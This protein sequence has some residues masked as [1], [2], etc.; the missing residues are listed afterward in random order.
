M[1]HRLENVAEFVTVLEKID[2]FLEDNTIIK[3]KDNMISQEV[4]ST[5][6]WYKFKQNIPDVS[7]FNVQNLVSTI[8]DLTSK[9]DD[10]IIFPTVEIGEDFF[11]VRTTEE[12]SQLPVGDSG[13]IKHSGDYSSLYDIET[14]IELSE[15]VEKVI[16]FAKISETDEVILNINKEDDITSIETTN[17]MSEASYKREFK[18]STDSDPFIFNIDFFSKLKPIK[19]YTTYIDVDREDIDDLV[20]SLIVSIPISKVDEN[21][22]TQLFVFIENEEELI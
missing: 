16:K 13:M 1:S 19:S 10:K 8:S 14:E 22:N 15:V 6:F 3:I 7:V 20:C 5:T 17:Q 9:S 12:R 11:Y 2:R 18:K 4:G 21:N